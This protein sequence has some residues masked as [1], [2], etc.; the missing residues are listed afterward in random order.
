M[1]EEKDAQ[2]QSRG[3]DD[4]WQ[5]GGEGEESLA[6]NGQREGQQHGGQQD[7]AQVVDLLLPVGAVGKPGQGQHEQRRLGDVE[8]EDPAPPK[9]LHYGPAIDG[10]EHGAG[11][12]GPAHNAQGEA[13][14]FRGE[15]S[16]GHGHAD[17]DRRASADGLD[18]P[19][20][21][22]PFE[23]RPQRHEGGANDEYDEGGLVDPDVAVN[24]S[25]ASEDGHGGGVAEEVGGHHPGNPVQLGKGDFQV[26]HQGGQGGDDHGLIQGGDHRAGADDGQ[27][28]PGRQPR[29]A[30]SGEGPVPHGQRPGLLFQAGGN[31]DLH[32]LVEGGQGKRADDFEDIGVHQRAGEG[33]VSEGPGGPVNPQFQGN[34]MALSSVGDEDAEV[35]GPGISA[36]PICV[37][38]VNWLLADQNRIADVFEDKSEEAADIGEVEGEGPGG[39][40]LPVSG[41]EVGHVGPL[42][43][44]DGM[45]LEVGAAQPGLDGEAE[46]RADIGLTEGA[47]HLHPGEE[48]GRAFLVLE[49][50]GHGAEGDEAF[51]CLVKQGAGVGWGFGRGRGRSAAGGE[52]QGQEGRRQDAQGRPRTTEGGH[53]QDQKARVP[54]AISRGGSAP[55]TSMTKTRDPVGVWPLR[56]S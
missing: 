27:D 25:Q 28:Q 40:F 33:G 36:N 46:P 34:I 10:A 35:L 7:A 43:E 44:D 48:L 51:R 1:P 4:E 26:Q 55:E 2:Q 16:G 21:D 20:G 30:M 50:K 18:D 39:D 54:S 9:P 12:G 3:Y 45:G 53:F 13:P 31:G 41:E 19:G 32:G 11:L 23:G 24:I 22:D 37:P 17:R 8:P 47:G 56:R 14:L 15:Q 5:G 49:V 6:G 38:A 29:A 42:V 52:G